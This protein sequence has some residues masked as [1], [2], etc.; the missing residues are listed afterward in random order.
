VFI[1]PWV[2][3]DGNY[4][5]RV[6]W[7]CCDLHEHLT[8]CFLQRVGRTWDLLALSSVLRDRWFPVAWRDM[9][10]LPSRPSTD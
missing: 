4:A 2:Q 9:T 10:G 1:E 7:E 5:E 6:G 3:Y 8:S